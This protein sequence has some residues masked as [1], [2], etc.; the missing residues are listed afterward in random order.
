V[1]ERGIE[2][3]RR[4]RKQLDETTGFLGPLNDA[5]PRKPC[6]DEGGHD[7]GGQRRRG[8]RIWP[9]VTTVSASFCDPPGTYRDH[10]RRAAPTATATAKAM[11]TGARGCPKLRRMCWTG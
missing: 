4:M 9:R 6:P 11:A 10:R 3:T 7:A 2:L 1:S 5:D 8:R